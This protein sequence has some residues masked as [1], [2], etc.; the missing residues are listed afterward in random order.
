MKAKKQLHYKKDY[1][2][3]HGEPKLMKINED[4]SLEW[5]K[6]IDN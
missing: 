6:D 5:T 1:P 2:I 4:I 3:F